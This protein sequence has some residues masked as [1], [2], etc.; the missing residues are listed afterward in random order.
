MKICFLRLTLDVDI[1][2]SRVRQ[3]CFGGL[4]DTFKH[5]PRLVS[6]RLVACDPIEDEHTLYCLRPQYVLW[7]LHA[8]DTW[9]QLEFFVSVTSPSLSVPL[10]AAVR[11]TGDHGEHLR[12]EPGGKGVVCPCASCP[13]S[14]GQKSWL[15]HQQGCGDVKNVG[16]NLP[17]VRRSPIPRCSLLSKIFPPSRYIPPAKHDRCCPS[18]TR[19]GPPLRKYESPANRTSSLLGS[20]GLKSKCFVMAS[21]A[22]RYMVS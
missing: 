7:F 21:I 6:E 11:G 12:H 8:A 1:C 20:I 13:A 5:F 16:E 15:Q 18:A 14:E 19:S 10:T 22:L 9:G 17:R 4:G 3:W 2:D